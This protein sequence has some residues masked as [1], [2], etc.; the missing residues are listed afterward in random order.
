MHGY[1]AAP[2]CEEDLLE[3]LGR[4]G[5]RVAGHYGRLVLAEAGPKRAAWASN[6]WLDP[7]VATIASIADAA[8]I[9]LAE[10]RQWVHLPTSEH[11]RARLIEDRLPRVEVEPLGFGSRPPPAV[12]GSWTLLNAGELLYSPKCTSPFPH[13]EIAFVED[14]RA[15]P[16][17]AYL[18][19]WELFTLTG[20]R[21]RP[22]D[23]CLDLG[24]SPGG[25][26]WVLAQ[27][28]A[29]VISVD[30][31]PLDPRVARLKGVHFEQRSA[32][33]IDPATHRPVDWLLCDVIC[34]PERLFTYIERWATLGKARNLVCTLKFQGDTD[35]ETARRFARVRGSRIAHLHHN[36]H[37]L[38]WW[39]FEPRRSSR[40]T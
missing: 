10:Q 26:T 13:G 27:L 6:V 11:R 18:K 8:R 36:K 19:L 9:L 24:S 31:A 28:G 7:R 3:E 34:Y 1:L 20:I 21:P 39:R 5:A 35:H 2:G 15:P 37:E 17:R 25:W 29:Q 14:R 38:T 12:L 4:A 40:R 22:G 33:A 16:S 23:L 32:F 30:K